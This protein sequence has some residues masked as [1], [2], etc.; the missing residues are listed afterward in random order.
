MAILIFLLILTFLVIIH[1]LGH[2]FTAMW[3]KVRVSEFG[4]GYP[5]KAVTLFTWRGVPFTLNWLPFGGF[6]RM[7]GEDGPEGEGELRTEDGGRRTEDQGSSPSASSAQARKQTKSKKEL[8]SQFSV[9]DPQIG[10]FYTKSKRARLLVLL[11]G[12]FMNFMFGVV[13]FSIIYTK[14]GIP[15]PADSN[16]IGGVL[17]DSPAFEAGF[18]AED[19]IIAVQPEGEDAMNTQTASQVVE[20]VNSNLGETLQFTI[21]RDESEMQVDVYARTEEERGADQGAIGVSFAGVDFV[22]YP[23]WQMPL[24]GTW[25]GIQ[26]SLMLSYMILQAFAD[27]FIQLFSQGQVPEGVAGPVGIVDQ[28]SQTGLF[29]QG[30]IAILNFTALLSINLAILNLLPIPALDGGRAVFVLLETVIGPK[31]REQIEGRMNFIGFA[32]LFGL[33]ILITAKDIWTIVAR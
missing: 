5:P 11:A 22:H 13:A 19:R 25:V 12:V 18:E 7:E 24:R 10:P 14:M 21:L 17:P 30:W 29:E 16:M 28:A 20:I 6:V 3:M 27:I 8:D 2:F 1:E 9:L 33:I 31:R 32:F 15:V 4:V 26:Q 23:W